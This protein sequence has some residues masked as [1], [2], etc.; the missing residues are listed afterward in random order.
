MSGA[1]KPDHA[2]LRK[3]RNALT[4]KCVGWILSK[5]FSYGLQFLLLSFNFKQ[6]TNGFTQA[7]TCEDLH[8]SRVEVDTKFL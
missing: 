7:F 2:H 4:R 1:R 5:S 6:R 3:K 8:E